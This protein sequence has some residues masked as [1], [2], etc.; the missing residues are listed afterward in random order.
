MFVWFL[1]ISHQSLV[2]GRHNDVWSLCLAKVFILFVNV[3]LPA[4]LLLQG[5]EMA[6]PFRENHQFIVETI[7]LERDEASTEEEKRTYW[8]KKQEGEAKG[9]MKQPRELWKEATHYSNAK[10]LDHLWGQLCKV[11]GHVRKLT[12]SDFHQ[13]SCWYVERCSWE[14]WEQEKE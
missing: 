10:S 8:G 5:T 6:E 4:A 13:Q 11:K 12:T 7:I 14:K 9:L 3:F 1:I 2:G